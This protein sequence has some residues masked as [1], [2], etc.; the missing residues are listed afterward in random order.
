MYAE[1]ITV[2]KCKGFSFIHSNWSR[3]EHSRLVTVAYVASSGYRAAVLT[4]ADL[5]SFW[6]PHCHPAIAVRLSW[7]TRCRH[8]TMHTTLFRDARQRG[9]RSRSAR[10]VSAAGTFTR[11]GGA[12]FSRVAT[13][14]PGHYGRNR[15]EQCV[16]LATPWRTEDLVDGAAP[17]WPVATPWTKSA[18]AHTRREYHR[19]AVLFRSAPRDPGPL[20]SFN[21][22]GT[23]TGLTR[24]L[25][26]FL[27]LFSPLPRILCLWMVEKN[28]FCLLHIYR[29]G[30]KIIP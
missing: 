11:R 15:R 7:S 23:P 16:P 29:L 4:G 25:G 13:F 21:P 14:E 24:V 1:I 10:T 22:S 26:G 27:S 2:A 18:P 12:C 9:E 6:H 17:P 19:R 20:A 28:T 8:F 3:K 30:L 5:P